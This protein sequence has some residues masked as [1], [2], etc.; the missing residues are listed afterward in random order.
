MMMIIIMDVMVRSF[1]QQLQRSRPTNAPG[2]CRE[3]GGT[4]GWDDADTAE[5]DDA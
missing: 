4:R 2:L 3:R 5:W 1:E